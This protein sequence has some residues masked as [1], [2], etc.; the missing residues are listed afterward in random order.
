M[1]DTDKPLV[2]QLNLTGF[3]PY[4]MGLPTKYTPSRLSAQ[5]AVATARGQEPPTKLVG[6][7]PFFNNYV[8][9]YMA[10]IGRETVPAAIAASTKLP[11]LPEQHKADLAWVAGLRRGPM[12]DL[13]RGRPEE[14]TPARTDPLQNGEVA[15]RSPGV[16]FAGRIPAMNQP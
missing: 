11:A 15:N 13:I 4:A 8:T 9:G 6:V 7:G 5:G 1:P 10:L 2:S 3:Y 16:V 14:Y 12:P